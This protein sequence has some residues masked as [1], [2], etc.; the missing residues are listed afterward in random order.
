MEAFQCR[1]QKRVQVPC[2]QTR[3]TP[4]VAT[5]SVDWKHAVQQVPT[6]RVCFDALYT[7]KGWGG[8]FV[9]LITYKPLREGM[10]WRYS[11]TPRPLY[12]LGNSSSDVQYWRDR[13]V[14]DTVF[15]RTACC[16]YSIREN[17]VWWVQYWRE[18]RV[19]G[20]VFERT[21]CGRCSIG[22]IGVWWVQY[23]R[24]GRVVGTVFERSACGRYRIGENNV[25]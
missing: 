2:A 14:V 23:S 25:L 6:A 7:V 8:D 3:P 5:S 13:R 15:E 18:R 19:V 20:T 4:A 9:C 10:G 17:C 22:E 21:A 1:A 16:S 24:D 12:P 11:F